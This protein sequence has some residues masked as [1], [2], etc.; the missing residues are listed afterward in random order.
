[1][2]TPFS[3][4]KKADKGALDGNEVFLPSDYDGYVVQE[5]PMYSKN[6][7]SYSVWIPN[8][9]VT[10]SHSEPCTCIVIRLCLNFVSIHCWDKINR[11]WT[12]F[13]GVCDV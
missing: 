10:Y 13:V 11:Y 6:K 12:V 2:S 8:P 5:L 9:H 4:K 3:V 1:M 7:V